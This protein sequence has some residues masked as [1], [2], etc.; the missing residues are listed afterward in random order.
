MTASTA[1]GAV[2]AKELRTWTRD[3]V[4][5]HQLTFA[6]AYAVFFT[7]AML[8]MGLDDLLPYTG[9]IFVAMAAA[10]SANLYGTDGT[11]LWLT[12]MTPGASDVRGR[13]WAW[14]LTVGPL[15]LALT[16]AG[17]VIAGGPWPLPLALTAAVLGGGAG[18]VPLISVYALVPG[19]DPHRRG[20]NPLRAS[21]DDGSLT[22]LAYAVLALAGISGVP[23]GLVASL[24]GWPGVAVGIVTG[25]LCVWGLGTLAELRLRDRGPE[26]LQTMR[27]GKRAQSSSARWKKFDDL[28]RRDQII[29]IIGWSFGAIPLFPQGIVAGVRKANGSSEKSWFLAL[30]VPDPYAWPVVVF[31]VLLGV[32]LYGGALWVS[33]RPRQRGQAAP[34]EAA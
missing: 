19:I 1:Q 16:V 4:R 27:T 12:L 20:G 18:I 26:L 23:A 28:P 21:E 5:N 7:S 10:M 14:L 11:V 34:A 8:V 6:L 9:A 15:G 17:A 25:A 31:M 24:Y 3:L 33:Y 2:V 30:H 29:A 32:A 22:G 13:Q